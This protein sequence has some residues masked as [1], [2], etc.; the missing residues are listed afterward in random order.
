[1]IFETY[2][3]IKIWGAII[4]TVVVFPLAMLYL[5]RKKKDD[6]SSN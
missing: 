1:M 4:G 2:L 6:D 3:Q 5:K